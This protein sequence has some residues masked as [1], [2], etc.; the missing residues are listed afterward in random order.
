MTLNL[1]DLPSLVLEEIF[2]YLESER[3]WKF[4]KLS[5]CCKFLKELIENSPRLLRSRLYLNVDIGREEDRKSIVQY[6]ENLTALMASTRKYTEIRVNIS[7]KLCEIENEELS[8]KALFD[9]P[10]SSTEIFDIC[11]RSAN[12]NLILKSLSFLENM[13]NS[14]EN[15]L[16]ISFSN[17]DLFE[18]I[19]SEAALKHFDKLKVL[20]I[21]NCAAH[22]SQ[23]ISTV[24]KP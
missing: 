3:D 24:Q 22:P 23:A 12:T 17:E 10:A 2:M 16:I 1:L 21:G 5:E 20:E 7:N 15:R 8:F 19:N 13:K 4:I 18:I 11:I 14:K 6:Q 9:K